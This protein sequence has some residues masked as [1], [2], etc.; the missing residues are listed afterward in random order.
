MRSQGKVFFRN[1]LVD[2]AS[3]G[4]Q[5]VCLGKLCESP[6]RLGFFLNYNAM[7]VVSDSMS[8]FSE[9]LLCAWPCSPS[10]LYPHC[11]EMEIGDQKGKSLIR[12]QAPAI[13]RV[14]NR[15]ATAASRRLPVGQGRCCPSVFYLTTSASMTH[16]NLL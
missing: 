13:G 15:L 3:S 11:M 4:A 10:L 12:G 1:L 5:N 14:Y 8:A 2:M 7:A 16:L 9:Q 6:D